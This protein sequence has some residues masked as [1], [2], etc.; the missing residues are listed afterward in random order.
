MT[1][2]HDIQ[3]V[4]VIGKILRIDIDGK[5]W[6][7]DLARHSNRLANATPAQC[8]N[9]EISGSGYGIHWPDVD[10]DLSINGM[11]RDEDAFRQ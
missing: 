2:Q 4:S 9:L 10:E 11:I 5:S 3:N 1:K 6:S 7:F 8:A